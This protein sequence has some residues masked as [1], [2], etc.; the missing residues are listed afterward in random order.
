MEVFFAYFLV[1]KKVRW[2]NSLIRMKE[3]C[4]HLDIKEEII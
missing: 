1:H 4:E 2:Y 3:I